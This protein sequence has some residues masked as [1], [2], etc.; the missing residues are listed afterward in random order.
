MALPPAGSAAAEK[1]AG[2]DR[3]RPFPCMDK[4]CGCDTAEQCFSNCC[5]NTPAE[6]LAWAKARDVEPAVL[7]ALS[8]R[9]AAA[10]PRAP[11]QACCTI[12]S[13]RQLRIAAM[14][15]V[16]HH[17]SDDAI[18]S[19][20]QSLAA[21]P[22]VTPPSEVVASE[23]EQPSDKSEQASRVVTL[24]AMLACGGI[25]AQ[26]AAAGTS[27]PP[28]PRVELVMAE[29]YPQRVFVANDVPGPLAT[30]PAVPPPRGF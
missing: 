27:L 3:S 1:I 7:V 21:E 14:Q 9:V 23:P 30:E 16:K 29:R 4:A 12:P 13:A 2:K 20:Y 15:N 25:V 10:A 5:C 22:K 11:V 18:C 24:Q 26:W 19:D 28:P 6:T 17:E 8:R